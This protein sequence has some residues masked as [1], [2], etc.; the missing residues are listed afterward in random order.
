MCNATEPAWGGLIY[1]PAGKTHAMPPA[2]VPNMEAAERSAIVRWYRSVNHWID[3]VSIQSRCL[4]RCMRC[5]VNSRKS[6]R[7]T[8]DADAGSHTVGPCLVVGIPQIRRDFPL[9]KNH[10]RFGPR[11]GEF[12]SDA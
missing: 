4:K 12:G 3:I 7:N 9:G 11:A 5:F 6:L 1:L 2:N 10:E 8:L